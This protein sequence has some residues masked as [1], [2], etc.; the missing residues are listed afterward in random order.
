MQK[1]LAKSLGIGIALL[2][3]IGCQPS[4][5]RLDTALP[6]TTPVVEATAAPSAPASAE[7]ADKVQRFPEIL[8][9]SV[10]RNSVGT[11]DIAVTISSPYDTP[12]RYADGWRV[13]APDGTLLGEHTLTHDHASEQ[14]FT[15]TQFGVEI[16]ASITTILIE[17][18]DKQYGFGGTIVTVPLP[19]VAAAASDEHSLFHGIPHGYTAEGFP[20]LGDANAAVTLY[21]YSDFL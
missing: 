3:V 19:D 4:Q 10:T 1:K 9:V 8:D 7:E 12:Q 16:P 13:V 17:G 2:A 20:Y 5:P 21:D 11:F 18:R 6:T 15:R 14:P